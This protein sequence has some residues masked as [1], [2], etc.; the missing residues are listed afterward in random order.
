MYR[1]LHAEYKAIAR[2]I[3]GDHHKNMTEDHFVSVVKSYAYDEL[4]EKRIRQ[5]YRSLMREIR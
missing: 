1:P 4:E 2:V 5:I 3:Q